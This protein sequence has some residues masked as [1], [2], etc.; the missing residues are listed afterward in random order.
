MLAA[1]TLLTVVACLG[2][3]IKRQVGDTDNWATTSA[4]LIRDPAIQQ[5]TA[6]FLSDQV[7]Q[8]PQLRPLVEQVLPP[9]LD[10]LAPAIVGGLGELTD[11]A[12]LRALRG[13]RFQR[14]WIESNRLAQRQ[15]VAIINQGGDRRVV[16]LDLRPL[17][18]QLATR[19]GLGA[20]ATERLRQ[21]PRGIVKI[22]ESD[23]VAT[24]RSAAKLFRGVTWFALISTIALFGGAVA[25]ARGRRA[26]T[27]VAAGLC[28]VAAGLVVLFVRRWLGAHVVDVVAADGAAV[29]AAQATLSIGTSLLQEA[30]RS[31]V[32]AGLV[33]AAGGWLGTSVRPAAGLRRRLAPVAAQ[34]PAVV[35]GGALLAVLALL[36]WGPIPAT[37]TWLGAVLILAIVL[38]GAVALRAQIVRE[39]SE[40]GDAGEAASP[41]AN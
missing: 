7:R 13:E 22:V 30:A 4:E 12:A 28:M 14:L 15:L 2:V 19:V 37:H 21:S 23:D 16:V 24:L 20:T 35:F 32:A 1:A 26:R 10:P 34:E 38:G 41:A 9:R 8:S 25:L 17:L 33:I 11:R 40:A 27:I 36:A 39:A 18:G 6:D 31:L 29:E 3:W 5:A